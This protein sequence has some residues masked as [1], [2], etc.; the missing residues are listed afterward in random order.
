[1]HSLQQVSPSTSEVESQQRPAELQQQAVEPQQTSPSQAPE[2]QA[3]ESDEALDDDDEEEGE[4]ESK[5]QLAQVEQPQSQ[6]AQAP[7][8]KASDSLAYDREFMKNIEKVFQ[9]VVEDAHER[10]A[11]LFSDESSHILDLS[12]WDALEQARKVL[13]NQKVL[14]KQAEQETTQELLEKRKF[15]ARVEKAIQEAL[16]AS[17]SPLSPSPS[18]LSSSRSSTFTSLPVSF[19]DVLL[20]DDAVTTTPDSAPIDAEPLPSNI[21]PALP[22]VVSDITEIRDAFELEPMNEV[23]PPLAFVVKSPLPSSMRTSKARRRARFGPFHAS[24]PVHLNSLFEP[25]DPSALMPFPILPF[26][27]PRL[28]LMIAPS[29]PT[30]QAPNDFSWPVVHNTPRITEEKDANGH[31]IALRN[32]NHQDSEEDQADDRSRLMS[33][34]AE[35]AKDMTQLVQQLVM[36]RKS[37]EKAFSKPARLEVVQVTPVD[38]GVIIRDEKIQDTNDEDDD[39]DDNNDSSF[40][41]SSPMRVSSLMPTAMNPLAILGA[42]LGAGGISPFPSLVEVDE[43]KGCEYVPQELDQLQSLSKT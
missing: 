22:P 14:P 2:S 17:S 13:A 36:P 5:P 25:L 12:R 4:E 29:R 8:G 32:L 7:K 11:N 3:E 27:S 20:K 6:Q 15:N 43:C 28:K 34:R 40:K 24:S 23:K 39:D 21:Q 10:R 18:P 33:A 31:L 41:S 16:V 42:S 38:G 26:F 35:L 30:R 19:S 1:V 37:E 9:D